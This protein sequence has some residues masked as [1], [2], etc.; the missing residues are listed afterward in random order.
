MAW[1]RPGWRIAIAIAAVAVGIAS[2]TVAF[3]WWRVASWTGD[4]LTGWVLIGSGIVAMS[5]I[6]TSRIGALLVIAGFTWFVGDFAVLAGVP[7]WIAGALMWVHRGVLFH[8]IMTVPSGR[9]VSRF[10]RVGVAAGYAVSLLPWVWTNAVPAIAVSL[11]MVGAAAVEYSGSWG[12]RRRSKRRALEAS[13]LLALSTTAG[14][15]VRAV[16]ATA[17]A[18]TAT[19]IAYE[20]TVVLT[21]A[22]LVLASGS[23]GR[24]R[25]VADLVV[26]LDD[27]GGIGLEGA[28]RRELADPRLTI[29][30]EDAMDPGGGLD[31]DA[32]DGGRERLMIDLDGGGSAVL[33][34][35]AGTLAESP[36]RQSV[37]AA[38]RLDA[39]NR[40]LRK[41]VAT[42]VD[43]VRASRTRLIRAADDAGRELEER[44]RS[45][46]DERLASLERVLAGCAADERALT[47]E[48]GLAEVRALLLDARDDLAR[49]S[50]GLHPRALDELGLAEALAIA[51]HDSAISVDLEVAE[52]LGVS[53]DIQL[54][55]YFFCLE[56]MVNIAKHASARRAWVRVA[57]VDGELTLEVADDGAGGAKPGTGIQ[58]IADRIAALGGVSTLDSEPGGGTRLI[59]RVPLAA[60]P[61]SAS[62]GAVP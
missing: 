2:V 12:M 41:D 36:L 59:G 61:A 27:A 32:A 53:P 31:D 51:L 48:K 37:T 43:A 29:S 22:L 9:L 1:S 11:A 47:L 3:T 18:S 56:G 25:E 55:A 23:I 46:A 58:G 26:E 33:S 35:A 15:A 44:L 49:F 34:V 14:F 38:I 13:A 62:A 24:A 52:D 4:L 8:A 7:G 20:I 10:Q 6:P 21:V 50:A 5:R 40:S 42:Q 17:L 39:A 28:L 57:A 30:Y 54:A 45:G 16:T 60:A 19:L